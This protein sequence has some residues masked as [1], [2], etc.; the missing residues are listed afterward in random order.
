MI[1]ARGWV[2]GEEIVTIAAEE[3]IKIKVRQKSN[4][5]EH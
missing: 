2:D 4:T 1:L 3:R 5:R